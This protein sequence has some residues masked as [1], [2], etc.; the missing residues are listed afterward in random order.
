VTLHVLMLTYGVT[1]EAGG[2]GV[3]AAGF[4]AGLA[5]A[6]AKVTLLALDARRGHWLVDA[7]RARSDGYAFERV[8]GLTLPGRLLRLYR[9]A[10]R[11]PLH[12][13]DSAVS[14][15]NGIWG[16]QS[17]AAALIEARR[18]VPYVVRPAGSLGKAALK[19]K[20]AKKQAYW[21]FVE[22]HIVKRARAL[23]CMSEKEVSELADDLQDRAFVVPTGIDLAEPGHRIQGAPMIV[24]VLARIHPIKRQHEALLAVERLINQGTL[25]EVELAGSTSD[26]RYERRLRAQ[27]ESSAALRGRVRFLGHVARERVPQVVGRWRAALLLSEQ[28]NFGHAVVA[29]AA[30]GVPTV[31]SSGVGLGAAMA[32]AGAG[33]VANGAEVTGALHRLLE[34]APDVIA[35][36]C[37]AFA[38]QYSWGSCTRALLR[39]LEKHARVVG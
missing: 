23:H 15:V 5:R 8:R 18:G 14:W 31:A 38:A 34:T 21:R 29:A 9:A 13:G 24:G 39:Q 19:Y 32:K 37:H 10:C 22:S 28:E 30:V 17:L 7:A 35:S 3:A 11:V 26:E 12:P 33:I 1:E 4:A 16:A 20:A 25:V 6:G 2:P 27:V 36:A